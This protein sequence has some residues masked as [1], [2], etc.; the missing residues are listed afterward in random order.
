MDSNDTKERSSNE[1]SPLHMEPCQGT[2]LVTEITNWK[3]LLN[4]RREEK[5]NR[6]GKKLKLTRKSSFDVLL[7][8]FY[9]ILFLSRKIFTSEIQ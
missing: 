4:I 1:V 2:W 7:C 5:L 9:F 8:L 6:E 3:I